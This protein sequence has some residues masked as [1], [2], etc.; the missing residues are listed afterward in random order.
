M[1]SWNENGGMR[2]QKAGREANACAHT[3]LR[4]SWLACFPFHVATRIMCGPGKGAVAEE[5]AAL[6]PGGHR[7]ESVSFNPAPS[8]H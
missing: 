8:I 6:Q 5:G 2:M 3:E 4:L 7:I 1:C